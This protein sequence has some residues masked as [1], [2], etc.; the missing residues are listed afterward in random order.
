[1]MTRLGLVAMA[2]AATWLGTAHAGIVLC[3]RP[4]SNDT[5]ATAVKI[6]T[7]SCAP[8]ETQLDPGQLGLQGPK[9]D[10]GDGGAQGVQGQPGDPGPQG[11]AGQP[12]MQ[13]PPGV[14]DPAQ[15]YTRTGSHTVQSG[16]CD[17]ASAQCDS[18]G[19]L[20][21]SCGADGAPPDAPGGSVVVTPYRNV[22][23][24]SV[25]CQV[26]ACNT[27]SGSGVGYLQST[28]VCAPVP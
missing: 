9:G 8:R 27:S 3:A 19:D 7:G 17:C 4:R 22:P 12:G 13:G 28:A 1:M 11:P 10:T 5:F 16:T 26:C 24:G 2:A 15:I 18:P 21:L 25:G 20:R 6:R 23:V 14:V